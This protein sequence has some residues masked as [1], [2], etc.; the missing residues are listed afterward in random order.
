MS[1][2]LTAGIQTAIADAGAEFTHLIE[3]VFSGGVQRLSMG[4]TSLSWNGRTWTAT[5]GALAFG[6]AKES[7]DLSAGAIELT[8]SGVDQSIIAILLS[9]HYLARSVKVWRAHLNT[10]AGTVIS[11]PIPLFSGYMNGGYTVKDVR[12]IEGHGTCTITLRCTDQLARLEERRGFQTNETSHQAV[13]STD[14]F[15]QHVNVL[16]HKPIVWRR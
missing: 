12:P 9:Q 10:A 14:R 5:K 8:L 6:H 4:S 7:S 16:A 13:H 1:R 3:L 2:T 11:S 15:F